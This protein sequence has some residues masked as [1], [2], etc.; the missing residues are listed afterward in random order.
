M[1]NDTCGATAACDALR[2]AVSLAVRDRMPDATRGRIVRVRVLSRTD[3]Q[4]DRQAPSSPITE[5][6]PF[7]RRIR[8]RP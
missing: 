4:S 7:R 1:T 3:E 8:V 2:V 5:C 6:R